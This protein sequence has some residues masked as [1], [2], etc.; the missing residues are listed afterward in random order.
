MLISHKHKFI[1]IDIPKTGTKSIR[2]TLIPLKV[3][4]IIGEAKPPHL[5]DFSHHGSI[6][7]AAV[8]F[9]DRGWYINDYLKYSVVRNPWDRYLSF[10]TYYKTK[11]YF[12]RNNKPL[13]DNQ[14]RQEK[15][16]IKMFHNKTDEEVLRDIIIS[17]PAQKSYLV[18]SNNNM[19]M[20]SIGQLENFQD[21]FN[22]FCQLVGIP[23]QQLL[24]KNKS[25]CVITKKEVFAQE[26]IDMV[27]EKE[28]WVINKFNYDFDF[29]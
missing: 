27:A 6:R 5:C 16:T 10:L 26:L 29:H 3:V 28:K 8:R 20:D 17:Y 11:L 21:G 23:D 24:H 1:I 9:K 14:E 4:D 18:D 2:Q 7:E 22:R 12:Y 19:V 13:N 15:N 25:K